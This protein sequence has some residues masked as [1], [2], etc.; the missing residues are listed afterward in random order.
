MINVEL[1]QFFEKLFAEQHD[2][3]VRFLCRRL[4]SLE[5]ARDIAQN[6]FVRMQKMENLRELDNVK[7]YLYQVASNLVIDQKRRE[8]LHGNYLQQES[9]N[10]HMYAVSD[11]S[12]EDVL[13]AQR[14]LEVMEKALQR[15][16]E[17]CRRAFLLHRV[18]GMSYSDIAEEMSVSVSSVE[19][20]ILQALK[21]FRKYLITD[22]SC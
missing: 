11:D 12:P 17:K 10:D 22:D 18:K 15:L 14:Q 8:R 16:P 7:A 5:D 21:C 6:A 3:L 9:Q 4:N 2:G 13:I 19:K 20:Y 1:T